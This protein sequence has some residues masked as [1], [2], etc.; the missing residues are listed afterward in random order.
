MNSKHQ[1]TLFRKHLRDEVFVSKKRHILAAVI[2]GLEIIAGSFLASEI[3]RAY[4]DHY[5]VDWEYGDDGNDCMSWS[6]ACQ[7]IQRAVDVSEEYDYINVRAGTYNESVSL[8]T[9]RQL[10]AESWWDPSQT[11]IRSISEWNPTVYI[12]GIAQNTTINYFT[13][14]GGSSG[15]ENNGYGT[16]IEG[17]VI[18]NNE[19][20][21]Y[22]NYDT[23][24]NNSTIT[25][26]STTGDGGGILGYSYV[27]LNNTTV[28]GNFAN[29]GGGIY[30][31]PYTV[32]YMNE[33][34]VDHN[35][36]SN[37]GGG[38]YNDTAW[39]VSISG[40]ATIEANHAEAYGGGIYDSPRELSVASYDGFTE[41]NNVAV[42]G[43]TANSGGGGINHTFL[44]DNGGNDS[45]RILNDSV[46]EDNNAG[47]SGPGGG[48]AINSGQVFIEKTA[49]TENHAN[50][51]GGGIFNYDTSTNNLTVSQSS[52]TGNSSN[53]YAG[54]IYN[55]HR[56]Q[57]ENS[58]I[59]EN[60]APNN[61]G[62]VNGPSANASEENTISYSTIANNT[63]RNL[64]AYGAGGFTLSNTLL[65]VE[66]GENCYGPVVSAG[67]NIASDGT[68][69]SLTDPNDLLNTDPRIGVLQQSGGA[70]VYHQL[71]ADS[72][73]RES[74]EAATCPAIDQIGTSRPVEAL[75]DRG[76]IEAT[77]V[78][79]SDADVYV[80]YPEG[81]DTTNNC[82][83]PFLPCQTITYAYSQVSEGGTIHIL[84]SS[85]T[86]PDQNININ[87]D[88]TIK[89]ETN[90]PNVIGDIEIWA[91]EGQ[92]VP[93]T[94]NIENIAL[95]WNGSSGTTGIMVYGVSGE[96]R[97]TLNLSRSL[98]S[99]H[100]WG[101]C[102]RTESS[103]T[104]TITNTTITNCIGGTGIGGGAIQ[105][106]GEMN[107][108]R[109]TIS[110]STLSG[111]GA[112]YGG[113]IWNGGASPEAPGT[114][115]MENSTVSG[116]Q[117]Q[118]LGST[119]GGGLA[120]S[121]Y[122]R[123]TL[124]NCTFNGNLAGWGH[125]IYNANA[126]WPITTFNSIF[127]SGTSSNCDGN[128]VI[129][130]GYNIDRGNT[131]PFTNT[132]DQLSADPLLGALQDNGG[133][134]FTHAID[135][136][137]S[138]AVDHGAPLS[139]SGLLSAPD[140][141][142]RGFERPMN[143]IPDVGSFE[144]EPPE[145]ENIDLSLEKNVDNPIP[146]FGDAVTFTITL[147]NA[148]PSTAWNIEVTDILPSGFLE[149]E[150]TASVGTY[151]STLWHIDELGPE[152][153]ATLEVVAQVL[154]SGVYENTAEVTSV[155]GYDADS[156]PNN[157]IP[158]EDD[159]ATAGV[160]P[161]Y[162]PETCPV[163]DQRG[164]ARPQWAFWDAGA[165][166]YNGADEPGPSPTP[167]P[168]DTPTPSPTA[169]PT[170]TGTPTPTGTS[171][172]VPT[173]SPTSSPTS[174][175]GLSK[176]GEETT[177][178]QPG[179]EE[180]IP[181]LKLKA[182]AQA[183]PITGRIGT[184]FPR[185]ELHDINV[186]N[187]T[188]ACFQPHGCTTCV[189]GTI[190]DGTF[191]PDNGYVIPVCADLGPA[192]GKLIPEQG[193]EVPVI[194]YFY[195]SEGEKKEAEQFL[196][197]PLE[198]QIVIVEEKEGIPTVKELAPTGTT[199]TA[200]PLIL[201]LFILASGGILLEKS[202]RRTSS[203]NHHSSKRL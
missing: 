132:G 1:H 10:M 73:A 80:R 64:V 18:R 40:G 44:G 100:R 165:Y 84:T 74:A 82:Q 177:G 111:L 188:R 71:F 184:P 201:V 38:I 138:P 27:Y 42:R 135:Q 133:P 123:T 161:M 110:N 121:F 32:L 164:V 168:T 200:L 45:L 30:L 66:D 68:C 59:S 176:P 51:P 109:S 192:V 136:Q 139:V 78:P 95:Y 72:P 46:I 116:N 81:N 12:G 54:G 140:H 103:T 162:P 104:T 15:V 63:G 25:E 75:C 145:A 77:G 197:L 52:V 196:A 113:G 106:H 33:G 3:S 126:E 86:F 154:D 195:V 170:G 119:F 160:I 143:G 92:T 118:L 166:E 191:I 107:I 155:I 185:I 19:H 26:N 69:S 150:H 129:S 2:I 60:T 112:D 85:L 108:A 13:I 141:D 158:Y 99:N 87:K 7:T 189:P 55:N 58:T 79:L 50:S 125:D 159:Q 171:T 96:G 6:T 83:D 97:N 17:C 178:G 94:V 31:A 90:R 65:K 190:I 137:S 157:H 198:K 120:N 105:N 124:V 169:T 61:A 56:V 36:A 152:I 149:I 203:L 163:T 11:V 39:K 127:T 43:N 41:L 146:A 134:T 48:I 193:E 122:G 194:S 67:Y 8:E 174:E 91:A 5:Y 151:D 114:L 22:V 16:T 153:S 70:S 181:T 117:T 179:A 35:T 167:T 115:V 21:V 88:V 9:G 187:G 102:V 144:K 49:I 14:E 130:D 183:E 101:G 37:I 156:R 202:R 57:I 148:G 128:G 172:P 180:V 182:F 175:Y 24:I 147:A 173:A 20:G 23:T 76:A 34:S 53:N 98:I 62:I 199:L 29:N 131:C 4:Y 47:A 93:V 142:Q 186:P 89:G 28:S